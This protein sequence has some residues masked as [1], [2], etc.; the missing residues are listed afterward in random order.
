MQCQ[1]LSTILRRNICKSVNSIYI[2]NFRPTRYI[3]RLAGNSKRNKEPLP[4]K[5]DWSCDICDVNL[6][7]KVHWKSKQVTQWFRGFKKDWPSQLTSFKISVIA[8]KAAT[9][10]HFRPLPTTSDHFRLLPTSSN[11]SKFGRKEWP[12]EKNIGL[13]FFWNKNKPSIDNKSILSNLDCL[14]WDGLL[15]L[16]ETWTEVF[17]IVG[18]SLIS[19]VPTSW[20][21]ARRMFRPV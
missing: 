11:T 9:S 6:N 19:L 8:L 5:K 4:K 14:S 21:W 13:H 20:I 10:D 17:S 1:I 18:F 3:Q 16:P 12:R 15:L 7:K 2:L